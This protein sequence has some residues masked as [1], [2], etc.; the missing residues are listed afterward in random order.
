ML[1]DF[2]SKLVSKKEPQAVKDEPAKITITKKEERMVPEVENKPVEEVIVEQVKLYADKEFYILLDNGHAEE[3]PGKRSPLF[4][5]GTRFYEYEFSRDIV[6]RIAEQLDALGIKY[7]ILVPEVKKD[8]AL[9]ERAKR[10]N[11][12]CDL[13]GASKCLLIS[14]H[15]NAAGK[16]DVWMSARGW[17]VWTTKGNTKSDAVATTFWNE[18][19]DTFPK[20]GMSLRKDMSDGDPDWESNFTIIHNAKCPAILTE[21]FFQDNKE[22]AKFIMSEEG[23]EAIAIVHVNA[24]RKAI[25]AR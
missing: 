5:D 22:D 12:Y 20:M 23:S 17:S 16:G 1:M 4:E 3:T 21:N 15:A 7:H 2:I 9:T 11:K 13:Y 10:A 6:R 8:I 19:N 24:I 14:I 25:D 18:A